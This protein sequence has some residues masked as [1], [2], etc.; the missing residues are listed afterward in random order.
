MFRKIAGIIVVAL[1]ALIGGAYMLPQ[2]V[3]VERSTLVNRPAAEVFPYINSLR[4]ANE[5][6][7]WLA[8]DPNVKVEYSGAEEGIGAKMI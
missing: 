7:P 8:I 5:W 4:R 1:I 2:G 3:H 6:S